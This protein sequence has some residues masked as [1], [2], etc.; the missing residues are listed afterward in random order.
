MLLAYI[1]QPLSKLRLEAS[2]YKKFRL[3][4]AAFIT[5]HLVHKYVTARHDVLLGVAAEVCEIISYFML[6]NSASG[7]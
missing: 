5:L 7:P 1:I 2:F 4:T 6:R 3:C